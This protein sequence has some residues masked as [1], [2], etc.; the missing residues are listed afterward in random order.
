M[1]EPSP[2]EL[3]QAKHQ[4]AVHGERARQIIDELIAA[5]RAKDARRGG[6]LCREMHDT[7]DLLMLVVGSLVMELVSSQPPHESPQ[8]DLD[9]PA[10]PWEVSIVDQLEAAASRNDLD[11]FARV[12]LDAQVRA[13]LHDMDGGPVP[14]LRDLARPFSMMNHP[15]TAL[16]AAEGLRRILRQEVEDG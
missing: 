7:P 5:C 2:E 6:E 1:T 12:A 8:P 14:D 4:F 15:T 11:V 16:L 9:R 13:Y 3:A 10:E